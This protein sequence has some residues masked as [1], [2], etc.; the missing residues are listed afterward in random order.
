MALQSETTSTDWPFLT[1][2]LSGIGGTIKTRPADFVVQEIPLYQASGEGT[3]TYLL[4]EKNGL[5]TMKAVDRIAAALGKRPRD[6]GYA[7]LKDATAVTQQTLSIE[8]V[9]PDA[10][11]NL[12]LAGIRVLSIDRHRNK[13]KLGHLRGNR[14]EIKIRNVEPSS[15]ERA[16]AI[17]DVLVR[18]GLA[19]YFGPQRFGARGDNWLVGRCVLMGDYDGAMSVLLAEPGPMD[20]GDELRARELYAQGYL[21]EAARTWPRNCRQQLRAC[22][23]LIQSNGDAIQGWRALDRPLRKL[24][25]SAVQSHLFNRITADRIEGLDRLETGDLAWKHVNG[26]CFQVEDIAVEQPRCDALEISPT[27]PLFGG[28]MTEATGA[29]GERERDVLASAGLAPTYFARV[30]GL[31]LPGARRP[32]RV[33]LVDTQVT[34]GQDDSG[35]F[36]KL[37]FALPPGSYATSVTREVCK[38]DAQLAQTNPK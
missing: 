4:I 37:S 30:D 36:L 28:R 27:G 21:E 15:T 5:S 12:D 34:D 20:Q 9:D 32:L 19:N 31:K 25:L 33:P 7:G 16:R 6:I 35:H 22:R 17:L 11:A 29:P 24:M 23:A 2:S 14:F 10:I 18:R 3:H 8:H 1:Q 38:N 13:I 26:A